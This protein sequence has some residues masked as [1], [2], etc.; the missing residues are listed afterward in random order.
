[1][2]TISL[3]ISNIDCAACVERI[4]KT[5][6]S[7]NG[8]EN[9]ESNYASGRVNIV[10][11]EE[12]LSLNDI[13]RRLKKSGFD[14][15]KDKVQLKCNNLSNELTAR[16][17]D[18]LLQVTGVCSVDISANS[19]WVTLWPINVDSRKLV[20]VAR[21][22]GVWSELG[23]VESGEEESELSRRFNMLRT[24]IISVALTMPLMWDL[25]AKVQFVFAT[26]IQLGPGMFF[27]RSAFRSLQNKTLGMDLLIA[28]ST[29]I[30][31][32]YSSA[33]A[34]TVTEN[35][36]LYFLCE[37]VLVSLILFGR[38]METLAIM[39]TGSAIRKLLRLQPK[40]ALVFRDGEEKELSIDEIEEHDIIIVRPGERI[41]VDGIVLDGQ[42]SVDESMLTGE[43]I[44]VLKKIGDNV[45]GGTLNRSGCIRL[46]ATTLGKDSVLQQIVDMV[47]H[48]QASKAPIQ[49][50]ADKIAGIF[51]PVIIAIAAVIFV[52]WYFFIQPYDLGQAVYT[53]CGVLVIACP[54]ALGLATPTALMVGSGRGAELGVLFRGGL[55]LERA[56]KVNTVVFDKTGTLTVGQPEVVDLFLCDGV[57][58]ED[59]I[60]C[61]A[62]V[63]RLSEHPLASA[64]TSWAAFRYP[65]T[66]PPAVTGFESIAGQGVTGTI[67]S[68]KVAC[69]SRE[70]LSR[71]DVDCSALPALSGRAYTEVC[72]SLGDKLLGALY[73]ADR[74]RSGADT[75]VAILKAMGIEVWMLTGDNE[76]TAKAIASQCCIYN[77][78]SK[79]RPEEKASAIEKLKAQGK[80][81]AMVGDG[82]NDTPALAAADLAIAMGTGTD[83]AI[84]C[85][86]VV[87][88][89]GYI[90]KI[91]LIMKISRATIR[92]IHQSFIWALMYNCI[93]IPV[94]AMGIINPSMAAAAMSLSSIGVLLHSLS[95]NKVEV[96]NEKRK[97]RN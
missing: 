47:H 23:Q 32:I 90:E 6:L 77:V 25:P 68:V 67:G 9:A 72:V 80:T 58:S 52:V 22:V 82:I 85:A 65:N 41:P 87:I 5:L 96:K 21:E 92:T 39:Q 44:P 95:L 64:I 63:E 75:A 89:G 51:V 28:L 42:C 69:G 7:L 83:I 11:D 46:S 34:F 55:E 24:L 94:A 73:I 97:E 66:L 38:Y 54:C 76:E 4:D 30:I 36:K 18:A 43:S 53:V 8:V 62:A 3:K 27:Y 74:L 59:L 20:L 70:M 12:K 14:I 45:V 56:Y 57:K 50:L 60:I 15:P 40:T 26:A 17:T 93:C 37:G 16:L 81:V 71:F 2:I 10:Y 13:V 1:M 79:V 35:I 78:I 86:H 61:A 48:S 49:R 84:D 29:S 33:V 88:P 19:I 31:Y 91:P